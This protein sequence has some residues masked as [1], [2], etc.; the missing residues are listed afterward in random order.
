M[1]DAAKTFS[2]LVVEVEIS[3]RTGSQR[4]QML[5]PNYIRERIQ[6]THRSIG[7]SCHRSRQIMSNTA[8]GQ[9]S[10]DLCDLA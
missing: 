6:G 7:G 5:Q 4:R 8:N 10:P 2:G 1:E 3:W 9:E